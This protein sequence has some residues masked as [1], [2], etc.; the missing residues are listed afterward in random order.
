MAI[1]CSTKIVIHHVLSTITPIVSIIPALPA[2]I[3]VQIARVSHVSHALRATIFMQG[4]ATRPVQP[5][6][7]TSMESTAEIV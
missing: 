4:L 7:P 5:M 2:Q 6:L 1:T 3:S